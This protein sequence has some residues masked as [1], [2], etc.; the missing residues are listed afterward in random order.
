MCCGTSWIF[1]ITPVMIPRV[2]EI[3]RAY[4]YTLGAARAQTPMR[5]FAPIW[6]DPWMTFNADTYAHDVL[7]VCGG[8]NVFAGED[9]RYPKITLEQIVAAQPEVILLPD[10]PFAFSEPDVDLFRTLDVPASRSG[11]IYL[12]DGSLITWH[13]TRVVY[14]LRDLPAL[15]LE[16]VE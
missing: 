13:G 14:A 2:R 3:E 5:V 8:E 6:H 1:L 4:D 11:H 9:T 7:R 10:E 15:F 16:E 12:M